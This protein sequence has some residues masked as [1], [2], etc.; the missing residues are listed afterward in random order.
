M[1][2]GTTRRE[3]VSVDA[4]G[5]AIGLPAGLSG[6]TADEQEIMS[7]LIG[8]CPVKAPGRQS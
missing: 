7:A 6:V 2:S 4:T 5:I 3:A 1:A 8:R